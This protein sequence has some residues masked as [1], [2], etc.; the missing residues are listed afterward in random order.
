[1]SIS[2][3]ILVAE[4]NVQETYAHL[5]CLDIS[6]MIIHA[7]KINFLNY[8]EQQ[9]DNNEGNICRHMQYWISTAGYGRLNSFCCSILEL[10]LAS[11]V[12]CR[13]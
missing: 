4:I 13:K 1:M 11:Y 6:L 7:R 5:W 8:I 12:L 10:L 9:E 3:T 2:S